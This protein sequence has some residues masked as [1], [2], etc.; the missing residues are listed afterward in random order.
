MSAEEGPGQAERTETMT[1]PAPWRLI[2]SSDGLLRRIGAGSE[3]EGRRTLV[4]WNE[5]STRDQQLEDRLATQE[6]TRD[7]ESCFVIEWTGWSQTRQF[8]VADEPERHRVCRELSSLV[9][10]TLGEP[11]RAA[12][13]AVIIEALQ[14]VRR[15]AYSGGGGVVTV[16]L[17]QSG[18]SAQVEIEDEGRGGEIL[19]GE[20]VKI[21]RHR[22]A[23]LDFRRRYPHGTIVLAEFR[24]QPAAK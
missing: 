11:A 21:M 20:G 7:D 19:E 15:H 16:R 3:L 23:A 17:R 12:A 1:I 8:D 2:L 6:P 22:A 4:R 10:T 9:G 5:G 14:N 13:E 18:R 24:G